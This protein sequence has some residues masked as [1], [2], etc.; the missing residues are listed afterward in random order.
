MAVCKTSPTC[1]PRPSASAS[2]FVTKVI[3]LYY[4]LHPPTNFI[5]IVHIE[6][7]IFPKFQLDR[8]NG[9]KVMADRRFELEESQI[10]TTTVANPVDSKNDIADY[11]RLLRLSAD[12]RL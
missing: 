8:T 2:G 10:L 7:G 1:R 4:L 3:Y 12:Y 11:R 9:S 6:I 5:R